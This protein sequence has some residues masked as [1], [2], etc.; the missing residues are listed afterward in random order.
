MNEF[1][2]HPIAVVVI[3]VLGI[4]FAIGAALSE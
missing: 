3:V 1:S 2:I 4:L